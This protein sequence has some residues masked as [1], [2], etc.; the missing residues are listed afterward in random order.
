MV[1]VVKKYNENYTMI[2]N[3]IINDSY[4]SWKAKGIFLHL[5]SRPDNWDFY[6]TEVMKHATDG[7]S[8]LRSG[9]KELE[10]RGYITR[11]RMRNE[12]GQ[13]AESHWELNDEPM[14]EKPTLDNPTLENQT[15]LSTNNTNDL[16][17]QMT[18][19]HTSSL[20]DDDC[21]SKKMIDLNEIKDDYLRY[22]A[23]VYQEVMGKEHPQVPVDRVDELCLAIEQTE[24]SNNSIDEKQI[25]DLIGYHF[26][27]LPKSNDG[28][29]YGFMHEGYR[30]R[31]AG[32]LLT[33]Q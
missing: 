18:D 23:T 12:R 13:V 11:K 8:S 29:I 6:E 14:F 21:R 2:S 10:D 4:L 33:N 22:Y 5:W 25:P 31:I 1:K 15:L 28:R 20:Y 30:D 9:L 27:N 24:F 19:K 16:S 26:E 7:R 32:E 17:K 3:R